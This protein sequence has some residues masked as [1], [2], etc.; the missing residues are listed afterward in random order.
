MPRD[1]INKL[2]NSRQRKTN[3]LAEF[4]KISKMDAYLSFSI[5]LFD[6]DD[7]D[8]PVKIVHLVNEPMMM[9]LSTSSSIACHWFKVKLYF[10]Y[11]ICRC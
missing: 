10:F 7:I 3:F 1:N 11:Q 6:K 9:N 2:V 4:I 5:H 8:Q